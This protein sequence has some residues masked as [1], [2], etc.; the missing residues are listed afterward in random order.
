MIK[1]SKKEQKAIQNYIDLCLK[2]TFRICHWDSDGYL[3]SRSSGFLYKRTPSSPILVIT[4]GHHTPPEGSF[5]ETSHVYENKTAAI[6]AGKFQ[7]FYSQDENDYAYSILP[8]ELIQ[9]SL[10]KEMSFEFTVYKEPFLNAV[11]DE[12]YGFAVRNNYEFIN[13]DSKLIAPTYLCAELY[14]E[15]V[16]QDEHINFF[17]TSQPIKGHDYYQGAS[18][19]PISD[20]YGRINSILIGGTDPIEFLRGFRLD[21]IDLP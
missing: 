12:A 1:M 13:N 3:K 17:S 16:K 8:L 18:G 7:V 4:A 9:K 19:S 2:V 20:P 21:N 14:M 15:L 5:I 6:N 10:T 11:K